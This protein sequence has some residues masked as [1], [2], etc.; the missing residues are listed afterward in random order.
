MRV[1]KLFVQ[2]GEVLQHVADSLVWCQITLRPLTQQ[3]IE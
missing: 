2:A 1:G 3:F